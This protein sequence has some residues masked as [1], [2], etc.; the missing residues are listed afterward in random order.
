MGR[1]G[2]FD[3]TENDYQKLKRAFSRTW[4]SETGTYRANVSATCSVMFW[5]N[6][7]Y[8]MRFVP[9]SFMENYI[10]CLFY[11]FTNVDI[12]AYTII[13]FDLAHKKIHVQRINL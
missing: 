1:E 5:Y 9:V 7:Y 11:G 13:S 2:D 6:T 12:L 3:M 4:V 8:Q 10:Y